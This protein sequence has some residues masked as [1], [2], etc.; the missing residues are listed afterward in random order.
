MKKFDVPK[1]VNQIRVAGNVSIKECSQKLQEMGFEKVSEKTLYGYE[2]GSSRINADVFLAI[3]QIC[4]C[5]NPLTFGDVE[6]AEKDE[7]WSAYSDLTPETQTA[8]RGALGLPPKVS[9]YIAS[10]NIA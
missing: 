2:R 7:I 8:I 1:L 3:C 4:G 6:P 9:E 5:S 10:E